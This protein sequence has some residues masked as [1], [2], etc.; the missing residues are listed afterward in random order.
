VSSDSEYPMVVLWVA[1]GM[2]VAAFGWTG[3]V[4]TAECN[5]S[6]RCPDGEV[7]FDYVCRQ[8]CQADRDCANSQA[9]ISCDDRQGERGQNVC[10]G[11]SVRA[12]IP[13][14]ERV[15]EDRS[16]VGADGAMDAR[17][18]RDGH[19]AADGGVEDAD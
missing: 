3:C 8:R 15:A 16:D 4:Q 11:Q 9:C 12:C 18:G 2:L 1:G 14:D 7:C 10:F 13:S 19:N 17:P 6:V 5:A